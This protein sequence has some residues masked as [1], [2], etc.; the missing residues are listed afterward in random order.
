MIKTRH[1]IGCFAEFGLLPLVALE[2]AQK[3][4]ALDATDCRGPGGTPNLPTTL[5]FPD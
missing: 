2:A 4:F 3:G 5:I 1:F